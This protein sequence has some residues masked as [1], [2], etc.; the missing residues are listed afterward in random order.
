MLRS[1]PMPRRLVVYTKLPLVTVAIFDGEITVNWCV[2]HILP[3]WF[4]AT[5]AS[6]LA[7]VNSSCARQIGGRGYRA[8]PQ[9]GC[10]TSD[11]EEIRPRQCTFNMQILFRTLSMICYENI[12]VATK[13]MK[14]MYSRSVMSNCVFRAP[15][16]ISVVRR[17][18][19]W[20]QCVVRRTVRA[21]EASSV[22]RVCATAT[23]RMWE[24]HWRT[25]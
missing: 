17:R 24:P 15:H 12:N 3:G 21:C 10:W 16:V 19:T 1:W 22:G 14:C 25:P 23:E 5:L 11:R 9:D 18:L 6:C 8:R 13:C 20:R 7:P 4:W 2:C